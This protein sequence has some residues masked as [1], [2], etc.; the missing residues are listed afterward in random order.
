MKVVAVAKGCKVY[1][2]VKKDSGEGN[3]K[4][5]WTECIFSQGINY[6]TITVDKKVVP[7]LKVGQI[8]DFILTVSENPRAYRNGN[9]A[10]IENKFKLT[11][12]DVKTTGKV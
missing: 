6:N 10:F 2:L 7:D 12:L 9:G 11:G 3:N 5:E 1:D 4:I 8:Y